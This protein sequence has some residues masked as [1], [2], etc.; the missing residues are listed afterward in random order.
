MLT[1]AVLS[2]KL[3]FILLLLTIASKTKRILFLSVAKTIP[4]SEMANKMLMIVMLSAR[5]GEALY[6]ILAAKL[7]LEVNVGS[8]LTI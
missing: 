3:W 2:L 6:I 7:V 1:K 4:I 8:K 5:V